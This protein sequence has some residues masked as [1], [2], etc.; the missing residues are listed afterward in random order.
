MVLCPYPS[1][2][3]NYLAFLKINSQRHKLMMTLQDPNQMFVGKCLISLADL[4]PAVM[5]EVLHFS[6]EYLQIHISKDLLLS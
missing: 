4:L 2:S 5:Q 3:L 6:S 1:K